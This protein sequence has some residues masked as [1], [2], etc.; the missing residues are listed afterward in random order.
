MV[1]FSLCHVFGLCHSFKDCALSPSLL[2]QE[3]YPK[4]LM[5]KTD[6]FEKALMRGKIEGRRRRGWQRMRWLDGI[7]NSVDMSLSKLR[8]LVMDKE[9]W[10]AAVH[11]VAKNWTQLSDW[12]ELNWTANTPL[13]LLL[14]MVFKVILAIL[15]SCW[16]SWLSSMYICFET[17]V[18]FFFCYQFHVNLIL[19]PTRRT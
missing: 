4:H 10:C 8:E 3:Q 2:F 7:T 17:F 16:I 12:T 13:C 19:K 15:M 11:E 1:L 6:S 14:R 9:V 5:Q 18:R